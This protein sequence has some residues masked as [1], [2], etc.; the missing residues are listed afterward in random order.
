MIQ[1]KYWKIFFYN[2][3]GSIFI[4]PKPTCQFIRR[5]C[6]NQGSGIKIQPHD[7]PPT[8]PTTPPS[9]G[10]IPTG[11]NAPRHSWYGGTVLPCLH[12]K[13]QERVQTLDTLK[14]LFIYLFFNVRV[15]L[16]ITWHAYLSSKSGKEQ[17]L[18]SVNCQKSSKPH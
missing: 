7:P 1:N 4:Y 12:E 15:I 8:L 9:S 5:P 16:L 3:P 17:S 2:S 10:L 6:H 14:D 13:Q 18:V 11:N